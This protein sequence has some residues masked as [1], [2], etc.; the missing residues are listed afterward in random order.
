MFTHMTALG[1]SQ[2]RFRVLIVA[3]S[4]ENHHQTEIV[5]QQTTRYRITQFKQMAL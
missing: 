3:D 5:P 2:A 4:D 1:V